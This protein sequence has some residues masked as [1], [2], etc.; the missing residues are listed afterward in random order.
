MPKL[1]A[2]IGFLVMCA[3]LDLLWQSRWDIRYWLGALA[4]V[5]RAMLQRQKPPLIFPPKEAPEKRRRAVQVLLGMGFAFVLGPILLAVSLT[6]M[7]LFS[8]L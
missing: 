6:L 3:G 7:V 4:N 2:V 5:L 1:L 8:N